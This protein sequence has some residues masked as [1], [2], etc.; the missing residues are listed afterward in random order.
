VFVI[1]DKIELLSVD[2]LDKNRKLV[3]QMRL[4]SQK[5]G[6]VLGWHYLLDLSWAA[7][8]LLPSEGM[9]ALD[10]GAGWGIMQWWLAGQGVDVISV[11]RLNRYN[12][13]MRLL[14]EYRIRGWRKE[15]LAPLVNTRDFLPPL[16]PRRWRLYPK[17]LSSTIKKLKRQFR[18]KKEAG[19]VFIYNQDLTNM[20]DIP[21]NYVDAVVSISSLEH[22]S[23]DDLL[24]SVEELMRVLKPGGKLIAT[25][26]ASKE[27]DWFHEPSK[28]WCYTEA[29]LRDVFDLTSRC[30]SNYEQYDELFAKL[31]SCA[32]L[33]NNLAK[34]YFESDNNGMP[35]GVWDPKY[36][37]V[38]IIKIKR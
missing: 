31:R 38:G 4:L 12:V 5:L 28:G 15:D 8:L 22:N 33:R 32:E 25:L 36:Q 17:K 35:W 16:S 7:R 23:P 13:S 37:S 14:R 9:K 34:F 11:D 20:S 3:E 24:A 27:Q 1:Q 10:A 21:D 2:L 6:I 18:V 29:T 30:S 26:G 19:T